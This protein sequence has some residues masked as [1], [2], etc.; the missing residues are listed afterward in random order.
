MGVQTPI[1]T[2]QDSPEIIASNGASE[3]QKRERWSAAARIGFRLAFVYFAVYVIIT[4]MLGSLFAFIPIPFEI[5]TLKPFRATV[6][7]T[8]KHVFHVTQPLVWTGSGSGDKTFDWV[9]TF[10]LLVLA[11]AVTIVWSAID[12]RS[13]SY[14]RLYKWF[15]IFL[16]F[17]LATTMLT[18]GF[19]KAVPMQMPF[20]SLTRLME[21]YGNFSP[22]G[23]L[24]YSIG[25]S[26]AYEI[27]VGCM[28]IL[29]GVL[30]FFPR[31]TLLGAM[32]CL[33]DT[34]EVFTL[35]MTYDVPVKLFA[36]QLILLSLL[37]LGPNFS[38]MAN[39]LLR[40]R[41]E[42]AKGEPEL[43][44]SRR[45]NWIS[46]GAQAAFGLAVIIGNTYGVIQQYHQYGAGAPKSPLYGIWN[47]TSY[48]MDG[49][50]H[51]PLLTDTVRWR[52]AMFTYAALPY[53]VYSQGMDDTFT[54]Y[55]SKLDMKEHTLELTKRGVKDWKADFAL[56]QPAADQLVLDGQMDGHKIQ[57]QLQLFDYKKLL[58]VSRG[59]HWVQEYPFN[60]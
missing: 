52:R 46:L 22:M 24:W 15:R 35:N 57:A 18:Y 41:T 53:L 1:A 49:M 21:P 2:M 12:R 8:A 3:E 51:P 26:K 20:P 30:L 39:F 48:K 6:E 60:K 37:L 29:G 17:S 59:F 7:W 38:R 11:I 25:A 27:F 16:R 55:I 32:V 13:E 44:K 4:Q 50:E 19:V 31:T 40:G 54:Q 36:F 28:E 34:A 33:A 42:Q 5:G 14:P 58:L 56:T 45:A 10:C 9:Q 47:V 23:V 43:F